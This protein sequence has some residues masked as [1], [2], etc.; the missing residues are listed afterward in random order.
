M[1]KSEVVNRLFA[2]VSL[3]VHCSGTEV[4][5]GGGGAALGTHGLAASVMMYAFETGLVPDY[6][7]LDSTGSTVEKETLIA[8]PFPQLKKEEDIPARRLAV[9]PKHH[10]LV[11]G[12]TKVRLSPSS[13]LPFS[14][15]R[16]VHGLDRKGK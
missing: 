14:K 10:V 5:A 2:I 15:L 3:I 4:M 16:R 9:L 1:Q 11:Y 7:K 6:L 8:T 12:V 13:V